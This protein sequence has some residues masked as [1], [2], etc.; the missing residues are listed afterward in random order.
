MSRSEEFAVSSRGARAHGTGDLDALFPDNAPT[1]TVPFPHFNKKRGY[2][3]SKVREA[4]ASPA[5][6]K[7]LVEVDPRTLRGSQP[8]ITRGGVDYYMG[9]Q[10]QETGR[11]FADQGNAG[12]RHPVVYDRE[13]GS[14]RILLAGHH[15]A[16]AALLKGEPLRTRRVQ[17]P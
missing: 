4:L 15:R 5:S 16:A 2:D 11:T 17:G 9:R 3:R 7:D 1:T 10:Y 14:E 12:N 6:E 8:A 13:D